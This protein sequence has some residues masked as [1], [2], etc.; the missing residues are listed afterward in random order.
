MEKY[1]KDHLNETIKLLD[2]LSKTAFN[3]FEEKSKDGT[4]SAHGE[5]IANAEIGKKKLEILG[6]ERFDSY[7]EILELNGESDNYANAL[8]THI[9]KLVEDFIG[10]KY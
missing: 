4:F 3:H 10:R 8:I 9:N 6:Q 7:E 5:N 1:I 2:E